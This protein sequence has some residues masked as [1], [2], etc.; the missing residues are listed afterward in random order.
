[1]LAVVG[2]G[3]VLDAPLAAGV[4]MGLLADGPAGAGVCQEQSCHF[5][6]QCRLVGLKYDIDH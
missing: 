3:A 4:L 6:P 2:A 5:E 1:M